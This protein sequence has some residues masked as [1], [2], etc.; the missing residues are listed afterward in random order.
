MQESF[1]LYPN[2]HIASAAGRR[3]LKPSLILRCISP[4]TKEVISRV[5]AEA[6]GPLEMAVYRS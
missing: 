1:S 6:C 2:S 5:Q 4:R 3:M